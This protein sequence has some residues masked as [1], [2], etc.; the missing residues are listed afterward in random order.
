MASSSLSL[1]LGPSLGSTIEARLERGLGTFNLA[2]ALTTSTSPA[3]QP[4]TAANVTTSPLLPHHS[5][6]T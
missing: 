5:G 2:H 1:V 6:S 4:A 3:S